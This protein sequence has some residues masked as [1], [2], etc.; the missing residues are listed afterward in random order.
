MLNSAIRKAR[1]VG[2]NAVSCSGG[3]SCR[4]GR[5]FDHS[6]EG[7][8]SRDRHKL[9]PRFRHPVRAVLEGGSHLCLETSFACTRR[10]SRP[11][12]DNGTPPEPPESLGSGSGPLLM[13]GMRESR[14]SLTNPHSKKHTFG[15]ACWSS[16]RAPS[17]DR[18]GRCAYLPHKTWP[19]DEATS[20]PDHRA[21]GRSDR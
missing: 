5:F 8:H 21:R 18:L 2:H 1:S 10:R 11:E 15:V 12:Q 6:A 16:S 14:R 13:G 3:E 19:G 9:I 17:Q 20:N 4:G 7:P